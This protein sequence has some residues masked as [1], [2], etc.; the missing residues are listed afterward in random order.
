MVSKNGIFQQFELEQ[1]LDHIFMQ[2][3]I[4]IQMAM[5]SKLKNR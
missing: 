2:N 1:N 5:V 3:F 4:A